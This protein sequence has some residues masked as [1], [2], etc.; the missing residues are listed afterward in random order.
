MSRSWETEAH[1]E[2]AGIFRDGWRDAV[3]GTEL[4]Q[5]WLDHLL[6]LSMIQHGSRRWS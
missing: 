5:L 4:Q 6:G 2:R 1:S 3:I